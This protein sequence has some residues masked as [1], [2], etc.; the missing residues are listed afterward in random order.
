LVAMSQTGYSDKLRWPIFLARCSST[1]MAFL[2]G[3]LMWE[4]LQIATRFSIAWSFDSSKRES[5]VSWSF[6]YRPTTMVFSLLSFTVWFL[7]AWASSS[8][9]PDS[10][11]S[12][13]QSLHLNTK[14]KE[15]K[16]YGCRPVLMIFYARSLRRQHSS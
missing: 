12:M 14:V 11:I 2:I 4:M 7:G 9:S 10:D 5:T 3:T 8:D 15:N 1:L 16:S 13:W 6:G